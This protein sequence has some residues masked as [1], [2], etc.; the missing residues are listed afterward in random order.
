MPRPAPGAR[1]PVVL[2]L[3]ALAL[4]ASTPGCRTMSKAIKPASE[5]PPPAGMTL[6]ADA[7][8]YQKFNRFNVL[9]AVRR[10]SF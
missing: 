10:L 2:A 9:A 7:G 8:T 1:R 3:A 5:A 4:A 6:D